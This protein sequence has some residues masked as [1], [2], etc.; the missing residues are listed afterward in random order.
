MEI[1][2]YRLKQIDFDGSFEYSDIVKVE[3]EI[4]LKYELTQ[5]Y[6][7]PFNPSTTIK[8]SVPSSKFVQHK[9]VYLTIYDILGREIKVLVN[10]TQKAGNYEVKFDASTISSGIYFYKLQVGSFSETKKMVLLP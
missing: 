3:T 5:N 6:P 2:Q 1:V 10:K 4:T 9:T 7:N 8:Y